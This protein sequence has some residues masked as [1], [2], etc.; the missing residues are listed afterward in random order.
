MSDGVPLIRLGDTLLVSLQGDL[1]DAAALRT[2]DRVAREVARI[3]AKG[4]LDGDSGDGWAVASSRGRFA[5]LVVDALGHGP[6]AHAG[7]V[8]AVTALGERPTDD[9]TG[10]V[11]RAHEAM[12]TTR[13]GVLGVGVIHP[14]LGELTYAGGGNV[15]GHVRV[16]GVSSTLR[17]REGTL[18]TALE[19]P[20]VH[21][22]AYPWGPGATLVL[23]SDGLRSH[24]ELLAGPGLL[25]HDP[26]VVAA[27]VLRDAERNAD[28]A[29]VLVVRDEREPA[30]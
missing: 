30:G 16:E 2:E 22:A 5:A 20:Q 12:R 6:L 21:R 29:T 3:G 26:T 25:G 1:D 23:A 9:L 14:Q 11:R 15:S 19:M 18:G 13:G 24:R 27:A 17:S 28:D 8:S 7:S 4:T 10:Y